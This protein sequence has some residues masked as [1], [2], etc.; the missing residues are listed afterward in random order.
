MARL[1]YLEPDQVAPEYR[2]MLKR[3][4]N[5][6][7]LLVNSPDMARAFNGVGNYIRFKSK[8]D[9]RLRELA[10]LQVGWL[11]RSE[12]EF[13]HHVKIGKEFGVTDEDIQGLMAETEGK[14]SK[15]E[16]LAKAILKG[17]REMTRDIGMSE[18]TFAEI[19]KDLSQRA[20]DRPGADHRLLLRRG[21]R[22]RH[23]EDRQRALL[24]RGTAAVPD[25][26]SE[27]DMRLKDKVAIVVGAGQSPGEGIGNGR[28]TALT[29]AREGA[30]VLCVDYNLGSA[31][32]NRRHDR[33]RTR[34]RPRP[35]RPTSPRNP[36]SRPSSPTPTSAGAASTSC[37]TMSASR[38]RAATPSCSSIT[39][40]AFDRCVAINLK[41]CILACKHV[42]PIMRE[43]KSGAIVNISSMAV[44]TTYPYVAYKATKAAMV[45][46]T[47]QLAYQNAQYGIRAN[48]ILP[49]LMNTPMAVDTRARE[50]KK[51]ARRGRGR[52][53]FQ[54]AAAPARWA[55]AGT[56]PTPRCSW[57]RTRPASSPA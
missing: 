26:G 39:E 25:P 16:P 42:I 9:P 19:K 15:L 20:H 36:T 10:I 40:E 17:A 53:R 27:A 23:H 22:A 24:Q 37:T 13:T 35:S 12:Y 56:S 54:G 33:A 30:K 50:F 14:P 29:F 28:A 8:L 57:P 4:T 21:A 34:A 43:Q 48:V 55:P 32:G 47:E 6:H 51:T 41:S 46:F 44:I 1:P 31:A 11:E 49:G 38:F 7:K 52:A 45:S 2:D 3:N 5:L 18:A